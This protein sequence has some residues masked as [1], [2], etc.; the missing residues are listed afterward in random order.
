MTN[1]LKNS[2]TELRHFA[3]RLYMLQVRSEIGRSC[4]SDLSF[5]QSEYDFK[6]AQTH[7]TTFP[8]SNRYKAKYI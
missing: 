6:A 2:L 8:N 5:D 4:S 1:G 7:H 3:I